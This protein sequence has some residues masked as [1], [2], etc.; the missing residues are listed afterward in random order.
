MQPMNISKGGLIQIRLGFIEK[1][2]TIYSDQLEGKNLQN[3]GKIPIY[4][5][6]RE[7]L[8][9]KNLEKTEFQRARE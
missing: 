1:E 5:H 6:S 4:R 2:N 7:A 8:R 3:S 9:L